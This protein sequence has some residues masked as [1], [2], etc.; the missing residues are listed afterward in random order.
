MASPSLCVC[1]GG[2]KG[3]G[4]LGLRSIR[5]QGLEAKKSSSESRCGL[6]VAEGRAGRQRSLS[7]LGQ[8]GAPPQDA[9]GAPAVSFP[10][11]S[12]W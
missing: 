6:Q 4:V 3:Q 11:P 10:S 5:C 8:E 9:A 12:F 1:W 2:G 7:S